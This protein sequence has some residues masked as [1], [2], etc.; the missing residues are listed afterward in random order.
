MHYHIPMITLN[1]FFL[2][3]NSLF[4]NVNVKLKLM[5]STYKQ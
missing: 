3:G 2:S 4:F 5:T 1:L